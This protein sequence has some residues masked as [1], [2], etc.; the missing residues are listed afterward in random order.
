M[1]PPT[2]CYC[3]HDHSYV[4]RYIRQ[5]SVRAVPDLQVMITLYLTCFTVRLLAC[6]WPCIGPILTVCRLE[7]ITY[8]P[9]YTDGLIRL[10]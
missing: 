6:Y 1:V 4:D 7:L 5:N 3:E 9:G 8:F 2:D 10:S